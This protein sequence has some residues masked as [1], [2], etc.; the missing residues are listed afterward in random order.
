MFVLSFFF[1]TR[2]DTSYLFDPKEYSSDVIK[3]VKKFRNFKIGEHKCRKIFENLFQKPF[4][5]VRPYFL[6]YPPTGKNLELD[7]YNKE[8]GIAFEYQGIQHYKYTPFFHQTYT[9]FMDQQNRDL[10][11]KN[12]C[13][14]L[15]I[16][17]I[18]IPDNMNEEKL[19]SFIMRCV[20]D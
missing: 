12:K 3:P 5:S 11:K 8:L 13:Q 19:T 4:T 9:D 15:G 2:Q 20:K 16:K 17:L 14:E 7:G 6:R 18:C 10:F 1:L